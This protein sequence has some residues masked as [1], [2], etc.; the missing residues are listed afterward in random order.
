MSEC[1]VLAAT[2]SLSKVSEFVENCLEEMGCLPK[3]Q[4]QIRRAGEEIFVNIVYYAY[5]AQSGMAKISVEAR[6]SRL[7][8]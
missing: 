4:M 6:N 1:S 7:W 8:R 5:Q 3:T 2:E